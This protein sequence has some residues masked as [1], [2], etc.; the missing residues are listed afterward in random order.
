MVG[1]RELDGHLHHWHQS[2][3]RGRTAAAVAPT[4]GRGTGVRV[5]RAGWVELHILLY[6]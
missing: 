2:T 3:T 5:S 4:H 1:G 6:D